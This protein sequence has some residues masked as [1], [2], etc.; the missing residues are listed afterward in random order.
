MSLEDVDEGRSS[1]SA[2]ASPVIGK[3]HLENEENMLGSFVPISDKSAVSILV[4]EEDFLNNSNDHD[5]PN[6]ELI[7]TDL[8]SDEISNV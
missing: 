2:S 4:Q 5:I 1:K 3:E 7:D 8:N 6:I